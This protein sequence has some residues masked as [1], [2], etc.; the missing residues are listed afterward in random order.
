LLLDIAAFSEEWNLTERYGFRMLHILELFS[1]SYLKRDMNGNLDA[2]KSGLQEIY[3]N[4]GGNRELFPYQE[5]LEKP[6]TEG[7]IIVRTRGFKNS[8]RKP[9]S[10]VT[11]L[12]IREK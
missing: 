2:Y 9:G 7:I 12:L 6:S 4:L 3:K 1:S 10:G 8:S 5:L 11:R